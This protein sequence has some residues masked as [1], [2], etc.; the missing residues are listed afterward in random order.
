MP[1]LSKIDN[2]FSVFNSVFTSVQAGDNRPSFTERY[3]SS[4]P[5]CRSICPT[6]R[7][8]DV[9]DHRSLISSMS[10]SRSVLLLE[11]EL[12]LWLVVLDYGVQSAT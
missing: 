9:C 4:L 2:L 7:P 10:A 12:S 11:T 1:Q 5:G 3:G 6:C 8:D